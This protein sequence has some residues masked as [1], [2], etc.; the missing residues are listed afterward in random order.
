[1]DT[2]DKVIIGQEAICPDGLGRVQSYNFKFPQHWVKVQTYVKDRSCKWDACNV[3][4]IDP[5]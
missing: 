1:M 5:L 2:E 4:L 3:Q